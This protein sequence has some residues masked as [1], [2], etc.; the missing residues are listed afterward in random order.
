M[1]KTN[2][3]NCKLSVI[4]LY[5]PLMRSL[6]ERYGCGFSELWLWQHDRKRRQ[7][8]QTSYRDEIF[9]TSLKWL[10]SLDT[11]WNINIKNLKSRILKKRKTRIPKPACI[12]KAKRSLRIPGNDGV[13]KNRNRTNEEEPS[14][15]I[16][17]FWLRWYVSY[18]NTRILWL[19]L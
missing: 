3:V 2:S 1:H 8:Q 19:D 9:L 14:P 18:V 4:P 6:W 11:L 15:L 5:E 12:L 10:T 17:K 13:S 16:T 7:N